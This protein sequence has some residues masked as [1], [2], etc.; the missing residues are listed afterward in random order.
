MEPIVNPHDRFFKQALARQEAARD[1][2]RYYLP[3]EVVEL[4]DLSVLEA[5]QETFVDAELRAYYSDLLYKVRLRDGG[6]AFVY[7]LFE[8]KSY[9]EPLVAFHLLRYMVRVWEHSLRQQS[10]LAPIVPVVVYHGRAE[11]KV[12][13]NL[14]WLIETPE[15]L[16]VFV[17]DYR[18]WLCD[19]TGYS[20]EEIEGEVKLR[21]ALLVLKYVMRPDLGEHLGEILSLLRGLSERRTGLEYLE[22]I[23]RYVSQGTGEIDG[24][25]LRE[26]VEEAFPEGGGLMSTIAERWVEQGL[27]QGMQQGLQQGLQ[28]GMQQGLQQGVRRGERQGLLAGIELGLELRFGS[29]G[30][31]L[32]PEV[33]KIEDVDVLRAI[34]AGL[35]T[36]GTLDELRRIYT[37]L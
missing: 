16:K 25:E 14:G 13:L 12:G 17:P 24:E 5:S 31:R 21:V 19:L 29:E 4:L 10:K 22:S 26:A 18:Y 9:A 23:L 2:M 35:R 33:Y 28:Q 6:S 15:S 11:W 30:L 27:Q 8:H 37:P 34:H 36:A 20:D 32:V 7:V 3:A 1:F